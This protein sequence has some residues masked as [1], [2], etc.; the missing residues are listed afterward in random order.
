MATKRPSW[1]FLC[2]QY[3]KKFLSSWFEILHIYWY[4]L[5]KGILWFWSRSE[6]QYGHQ[7]AILDFVSAQYLKKRLSNW[8]EIWHIYWYILVEGQV[9][10]WTRSEIQYGRQAAILDFR[11]CSISQEAFKQL[12]WNFCTFIGT[13]KT[14][15][16]Y[17]FGPN[18]KSN[19]AARWPSRIFVSAQYLKKHLSNYFKKRLSN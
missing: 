3:L 17:D 19:M 16:N 15:V 2:A 14:K 13:Y 7:V 12:I 10:F 18:R 11:F 9:C 1:I 8:F 4:I 6:N 5:G